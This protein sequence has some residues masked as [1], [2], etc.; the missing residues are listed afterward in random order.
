MAWR[1][2]LLILLL[3]PLLE[4]QQRSY[5]YLIGFRT[6][7]IP[8]VTRHPSENMNSYLPLLYFEGDTLFLRGLE[9]GVHLYEKNSVSVDALARLRFV[10]M[11]HSAPEYFGG[12]VID[13]GF[14]L[15][16]QTSA[17]K[18]SLAW[19]Q[20]GYA[21]SYWELSGRTSLSYASATFTPFVQL[22]Y[23]DAAFNTHY[24]G[25]EQSL[26]ADIAPTVGVESS[27]AIGDALR[28]YARLKTEYSGSNVAAA[29]S[30]ESPLNS[31]LITGIKLSGLPSQRLQHHPYMQTGFG[32]ATLGSF[33]QLLTLS[34]PSDPYAHKMA[35]LFYGHPLSDTLMGLEMPL[36]LHSGIA[37]HFES[38]QQH[39]ALELVT[40]F[41]TFKALPCRFELGMAIGLSYIS[42]TTY[43]ENWANEK[44]GYHETSRLMNHLDLSIENRVAKRVSVGY[45]WFH[46]S[47]VF[48][49]VQSFGQIKGGSN[50]HHFFLKFYM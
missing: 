48:E 35:S 39:R 14:S 49:S 16:W 43:V 33:S 13:S 12:D 3:T 32:I 27:V 1:L 19:L 17:S 37:Y 50:Y 46:R 34:A 40:A 38:E 23:R 28:L 29:D 42:E 41:K 6:A 9:G 21:R 36:Y 15:S 47:G 30:V 20:D 8:Y 4:A 31:E 24:Y 7:S 45:G 22:Q 11:P 5:G 44:D 25:L 26:K 2:F 10:D 18:L